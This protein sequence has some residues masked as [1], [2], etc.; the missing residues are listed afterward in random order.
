MKP[1][2][3]QSSDNASTKDGETA[4]STAASSRATTA[5][6][7]NTGPHQFNDD[8]VLCVRCKRT[9]K[10]ARN[11]DMFDDHMGQKKLLCESFRILLPNL[12]G[13]RPAREREWTLRCVRAIVFAKQ[14]E[15][16]AAERAA[17]AP[18]RMPEFVYGW[19]F[20]RVQTLARG[21]REVCCSNH[22]MLTE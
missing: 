2:N 5:A 6:A 13:Q 19:F 22:V 17:R 20:P 10:A 7:N 3:A 11:L 18:V 9:L 14:R 1:I 8:S 12:L 15:A 16:A 21:D 4:P